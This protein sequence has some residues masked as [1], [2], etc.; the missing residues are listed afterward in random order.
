MAEQW[1]KHTNEAYLEGILKEDRAVLRGLYDEFQPNIIRYIQNNGG[2][3]EEAQDIFASA[4]V[5]VYRKVRAGRL[6]LTSPFSAYLFAICQNLWLKTYRKKSRMA[7]VTESTER[8]LADETPTPDEQL[9]KTMLHQV[10]R[11]LFSRISDDCRQIIQMRWNGHDYAEIRELMGHKSEGYT[12]KRKHVCH[13]RLTEL[14]R[15]DARVK[16]YF[17]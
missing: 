12:R 16:E 4:I 14:V 17:L 13:E 10:I 2:T 11:E 3:H 6:V 7:G 8:V 5:V 9:E 15:N 1:G